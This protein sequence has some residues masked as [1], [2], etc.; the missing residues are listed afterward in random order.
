MFL[1]IEGH[2]LVDG[3]IVISKEDVAAYNEQGFEK[4]VSNQVKK[5][6]YYYSYKY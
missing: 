6:G 4:F 2:V 1:L 5:M 3:D